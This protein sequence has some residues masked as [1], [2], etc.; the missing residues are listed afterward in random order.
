MFQV[1]PAVFAA[2]PTPCLVL[3][4]EAPEYAVV[5]VNAA[6]GRL[7][8]G[9]EETLLHGSAA[10]A[11]PGPKALLDASLAQVIATKQAH[12]LPVQAYRQPST[13]ATRYGRPENT[14]VLTEA[15]EVAYVLHTVVEVPALPH[16]AGLPD[17]PEAVVVFDLAGIARRANDRLEQLTQLPNE[18]LLGQHFSRFIAPNDRERVAEHFRQAAQGQP[19]H[20]M[21]QSSPVAGRRLQLRLMT[22]P[23]IL[24]GEIVGV[25][26]IAQDVTERW[27]TN[28][29][30]IE[31]EHRFR[32]AFDSIADVIFIVDVHPDGGYSFNNVNRAFAATTGLPVEQVVGRNVAEIIPESALQLVLGNYAEAIRSRQRVMWEETSDY[33]SG[34]ITGEVSVTPVFDDNGRCS[35]LIGIVHDLTAQRQADT[36]QKKMAQEMSR[37]NSDLQQFT[38]IVSHNLRAPLANAKGFASLLTRVDKDSEVFSTS[39][40]NLQTSLQQLDGIMQDV[41]DILSIRDK[42]KAFGKPE[43]VSLAAACQQACR[44]LEKALQES[45]GTVNMAISEDLLLQGNRA[46][47]YSIFY[48]LLSNAIKYRAAERPLVV[49]IE[50]HAEGASL[51]L[52]IADNGL[53]FEQGPS[54]KDVFQL[55]QR[56]H[57][58]PEGR[59]IG[60]FLVKAHVEAMGGTIEVRSQVNQG[61][62]F[63]IRFN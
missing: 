19:Q 44:S 25:Y 28:R 4:A 41:T 38:Y 10:A 53:G 56:F 63:A 29:A 48:N 23:Q 58:G 9:A 18:A 11:F 37:Q 22:L 40:T 42:Q 8:P 7:V 14:P 16:G 31:R 17:H 21:A 20:Y 26:A 36:R 6:F 1:P 15:G 12:T 33:P 62:C 45:H 2:L 50:A 57:T 39:L 61:S 3:A 51:A 59:G 46:Y 34:Q 47:L 49:D 52:T 43:T 5:A 54:D 30:M 60:L 27:E 24:D 55:Y 35:Q 13:A 32:V